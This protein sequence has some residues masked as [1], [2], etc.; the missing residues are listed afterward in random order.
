MRKKD[1]IALCEKHNDAAFLS[2]TNATLID[3]EFCQDML[4]VGNFVPAISLEALRRPTTPAAA[5]A[6]TRRSQ[7]PW[8]C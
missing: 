7:T 5:R 6:C 1:L 3:E 2:F 4:R 8:P